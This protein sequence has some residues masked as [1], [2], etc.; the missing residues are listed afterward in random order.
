M[1]KDRSKDP[2][3]EPKRP[4]PT[5]PSTK[6]APDNL[7]DLMYQVKVSVEATR[8]IRAAASTFELLKAAS[9]SPNRDRYTAVIIELVGL[10]ANA[11]DHQIAALLALVEDLTKVVDALV[12]AQ[13]SERGH[14]AEGR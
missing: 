14:S 7:T 13:T 11:T 1:A 3:I 10:Q 2:P 6:A 8:R 9:E 5:E 12:E 4:N